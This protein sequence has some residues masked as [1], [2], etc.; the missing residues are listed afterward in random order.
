MSKLNF[1]ASTSTRSIIS[2]L[3]TLK[4]FKLGHLVYS[5]T[6]SFCVIPAAQRR[7]RNGYTARRQQQKLQQQRQQLANLTSDEESTDGGSVTRCICG[8]SRKLYER[9]FHRQAYTQC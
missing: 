4:S 8:E 5:L 7:S 9:N 1:V 2:G 6:L 3:A